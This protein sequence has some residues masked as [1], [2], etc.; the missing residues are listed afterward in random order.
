MKEKRLRWSGHIVKLRGG[1]DHITK[2]VRNLI[3][4]ERLKGVRL[5]N[6]YRDIREQ[7]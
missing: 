5:R 3:I 1:K 6:I 7:R 2:K 4:E